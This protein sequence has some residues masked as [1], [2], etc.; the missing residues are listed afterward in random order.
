M[1]GLKKELIRSGKH[2]VVTIVFF[3][4]KE[5]ADGFRS[6][7]TGCLLIRWRFFIQKCDSYTVW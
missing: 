7:E 3:S 4:S 2:V 1:K 6:W 5:N